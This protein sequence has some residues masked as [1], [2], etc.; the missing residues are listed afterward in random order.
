MFQDPDTRA[1]LGTQY[2]TFHSATVGRPTSYLLY[3]PPDY[4]DQGE[5]SSARYPVVYWLHGLNGT[6]RDGAASF[7][8][9]LDANIRSGLAPPMIAVLVNGLGDSRYYDSF[10]GKRPVESV[11]VRD[12]IPHVDSSY[13][14]LRTR[15]CRAI[16]GFSMGGFG[17]AHLGFKYPD[18]F[19]A[20]SIMAG[21]LLD[22]ESAAGAPDLITT[23]QLFKKCFGTR[24]YF[25]AGSPWVVVRDHAEQIRAQTRIRMAVGENDALCGR[26]RRY[27]QLLNELNIAHEFTALPHVGHDAEAIYAAL[28]TGGFSFYRTAFSCASL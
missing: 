24:E 19:G 16:E 17:A 21:A 5:Q 9:H 10:D 28:G 7:V 1:P 3:L 2:R 4:F 23:P 26:N 22:D 18:L 6:Q 8:P 11:I 27:H 25:H 14:T 15:E 12:L 20:V 13:R